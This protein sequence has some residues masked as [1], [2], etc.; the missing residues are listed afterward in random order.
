MSNFGLNFEEPSIDFGFG[1]M[2]KIAEPDE[3]PS[4]SLLFTLF[5]VH[6]NP[7]G[8]VDDWPREDSDDKGKELVKWEHGLL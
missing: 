2:V 3:E 4:D 5:R 7:L 1:T 6:V 8:V